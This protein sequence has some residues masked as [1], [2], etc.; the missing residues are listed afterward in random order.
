[1]EPFRQIVDVWVYY[2]LREADFLTYEH[3]LGL[4]NLLNA[5]VRYGKE[6]CSVTVAM[7]KFVKGFI[8]CIEDKETSQFFCPIVSSLE[9]EKS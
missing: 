6:N 3:R 8:R 5:K 4:T 9:M 2:H 1:M 7:D